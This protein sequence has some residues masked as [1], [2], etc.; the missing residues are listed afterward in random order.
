M[1]RPATWMVVM[2]ECSPVMELWLKSAKETV[3]SILPEVQKKYPSATLRCGVV[4]YG[5]RTDVDEKLNDGCQVL[6]FTSAEKAGDFIG[7]L[8]GTRTGG[9][10]G[11]QDIA[12][13]FQ[14]GN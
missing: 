4:A 13:A 7:G 14:Q 9:A 3:L 6:P 11:P 5:F 8:V 1:K 2:I 12:S 10:E